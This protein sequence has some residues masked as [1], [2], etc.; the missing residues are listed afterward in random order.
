MRILQSHYI[1]ITLVCLF[2]VACT[3]PNQARQQRTK[4]TYTLVSISNSNTHIAKGSTFTWLPQKRPVLG[5]TRINK[6][7]IGQLLDHSF[8]ETL[9]KQGFIW[10]NASNEAQYQLTYVAIAGD[11]VSEADINRSFQINPGLKS[12]SYISK[13]YEKGT[14]IVDII[15]SRSGQSVWRVSMQANLDRDDDLIAR[16]Q[17]INGAVQALISKIP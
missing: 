10:R 4:T 11:A 9:K 12:D 16:Q 6:S 5:N 2:S 3:V 7:E 1:Y 15:D 14:L 17:R 13:K 8:K